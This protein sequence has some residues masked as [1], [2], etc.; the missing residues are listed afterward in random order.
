MPCLLST[1][2]M[3]EIVIVESRYMSPNSLALLPNLF[4]SLAKCREDFSIHTQFYGA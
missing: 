1:E 3:A 4:V 2:D